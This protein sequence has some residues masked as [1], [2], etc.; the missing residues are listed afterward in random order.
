MSAMQ[1]RYKDAVVEIVILLR[2]P[3]HSLLHLPTTTSAGSS[4]AC[5]GRRDR[6]RRQPSCF[7]FLHSFL[8]FAPRCDARHLRHIFFGRNL[9]WGWKLD[10]FARRSPAFRISSSFAGRRNETPRRKL[11][12]LLLLLILITNLGRKCGLTEATAG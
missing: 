9:F 12:Q 11:K 7:L 1:S 3:S 5:S 8:L 4:N 10:V 2:R 6:R